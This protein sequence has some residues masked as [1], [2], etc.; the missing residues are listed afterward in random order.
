MRPPSLQEIV[1]A[2]RALWIE[3]HPFKRTRAG[4]L[5]ALAEMIFTRPG[6]STVLWSQG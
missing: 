1:E 6:M 5:L 2:D 4:Y 3:L